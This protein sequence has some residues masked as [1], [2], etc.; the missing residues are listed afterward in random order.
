MKMKHNDA[1][2]TISKQGNQHEKNGK[3]TIL[4]EDGMSGLE[5]I[6]VSMTFADFAACIGG[7]SYIGAEYI[8]T[9][10]HSTISHI[11]KLRLTK[12]AY[13]SFDKIS[14]FNMSKEQ[15]QDIIETDFIENWKDKEWNLFH[16][17]T[18]SQQNGDEWRYT[19]NKYV[20]KDSPEGVEYLKNNRF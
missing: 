18:N 20:D 19:I 12:S 11:G 4:I 16:T 5:I 6:E 9:P 7:C 8:S 17:N 10:S 13:I 2:V 15:Q 1:K 14:K 3:F